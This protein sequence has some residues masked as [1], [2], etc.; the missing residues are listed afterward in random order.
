M[1]S[2]ALS[3]AILKIT[4]KIDAIIQTVKPL[5]E[6][7]VTSFVDDHVKKLALIGTYAKFFSEL[8]VK[9]RDEAEGV[10]E[11]VL[12][13]DAE[14]EK[15]VELLLDKEK[16]FDDFLKSID[17]KWKLENEMMERIEASSENNKDLQIGDVFPN[18]IKFKNTENK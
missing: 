10:W 11:R 2:S 15:K 17:H 12:I 16:E 1:D 14:V 6:R 4:D 13:R 18:G 7:S 9:G 8:N 3:S 5:V